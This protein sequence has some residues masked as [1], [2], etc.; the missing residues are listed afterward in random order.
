M[1]LEW[2][3]RGERRA[4]RERERERWTLT[5]HRCRHLLSAADGFKQDRASKALNEVSKVLNREA[6][7]GASKP[8]MIYFERL[9]RASN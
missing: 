7:N 3:R 9:N 6:L 8:F 2:E 4:R 5:C 1:K